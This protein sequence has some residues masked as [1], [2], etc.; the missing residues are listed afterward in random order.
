MG[1]YGKERF[2]QSI[3]SIDMFLRESGMKQN[4]QLL[5]IFD[6]FLSFSYVT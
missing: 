1:K 3:G 4:R 5:I 2:Y 6:I